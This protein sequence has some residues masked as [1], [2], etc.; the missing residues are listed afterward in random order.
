MLF[1]QQPVLTN[2]QVSSEVMFN[3][4]TNVISRIMFAQPSFPDLI[5]DFDILFLLTDQVCDLIL[6][7]QRSNHN[8]H[9]SVLSLFVTATNVFDDKYIDLNSCCY[10]SVEIKYLILFD[11]CVVNLCND[12]HY[13]HNK[14]QPSRTRS[15]KWIH[16]VNRY[17]DVVA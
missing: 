17:I 13:K 9:S 8:L 16:V 10:Y 5:V 3:Q 6:T 15:E 1:L 12:V 14:K 4:H 11:G 2:L 7:Y